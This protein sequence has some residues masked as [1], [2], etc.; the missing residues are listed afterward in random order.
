MREMRSNI[1]R[2]LFMNATRSV[3]RRLVRLICWTLVCGA[4]AVLVGCSSSGGGGGGGGPN[5][6]VS[7]HYQGGA[8]AASG[9]KLPVK[10]DVVD[11]RTPKAV[12]RP[13]GREVLAEGDKGK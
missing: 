8:G 3:G 2:R 7:P 11:A 9:N 1:P 6:V 4:P 12:T 10:V 5:V 13:D